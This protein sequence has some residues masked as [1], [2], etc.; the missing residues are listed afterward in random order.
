MNKAFSNF[1]WKNAPDQSTP[2]NAQNL[3]KMNNAIDA[4]DDRVLDLDAESVR[5]IKVATLPETNIQTY[6]T[7]YLL[8]PETG[9]V[10]TLH[11]YYNNEWIQIGGS[12]SSEPPSGG[13]VSFSDGTDEEIMNMIQMHYNGEINIA[14]YWGIGDERKIHL[15]AMTTSSPETHVEQDM[16]F[17]IIGINHDVLYSDP[18]KK[19]CVTIQSKEVLGSAGEAETG[20]MSNG[21]GAKWD[22]CIRKS[23]CNNEFKKALP[24]VFGDNIKEVKKLVKN[25]TTGQYSSSRN[26]VFFLTSANV[27]SEQVSDYSEEIYPYFSDQ[28]NVIKKV[29]DNGSASNLSFPWWLSDY[30]YYNSTTYSIF[31]EVLD[32]GTRGNASSKYQNVG[33]APAFCL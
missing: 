33:L 8:K 18:T 29:N 6:P 25:N 32:V 16:T 12:G 22:T 9:N 3:N 1:E 10:W 11:E 7:R 17:V 14:D 28:S 24:I 2:V 21:F 23:W 30:G 19:A 13:V 27:F 31:F 26:E 5:E 20:Y 4:I 15:N